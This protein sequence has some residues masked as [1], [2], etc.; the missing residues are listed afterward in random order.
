MRSPGRMVV[1]ISRDQYVLSFFLKKF[2][3]LLVLFPN[4]WIVPHLQ[5]IMFCVSSENLTYFLALSALSSRPVVWRET[6]YSAF[7]FMIALFSSIT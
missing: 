5:R 2:F 4:I 3:D 7:V 1:G 6:T